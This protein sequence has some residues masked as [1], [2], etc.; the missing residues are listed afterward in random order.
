MLIK[1]AADAAYRHGDVSDYAIALYNLAG[2]YDT[3]LDL[4]SKRI[5]TQLSQR[6]HET[7]VQMAMV[8]VR[9][10]TQSV[11]RAWLE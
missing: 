8:R 7:V 10:P 11:D 3:V 1:P 6:S 4:L 9:T 2:E 5:S